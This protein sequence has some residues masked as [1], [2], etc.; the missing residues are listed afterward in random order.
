MSMNWEAVAAISAAA[1]TL[2]VLGTMVAAVIQLRKMNQSN[3][4]QAYMSI[5][6][7]LQV[8]EIREARRFLMMEMA[9]KKEFSCWQESEIVKCE[10]VCAAYDTVGQLL[11]QGAAHPEMVVDHWHS[12]IV[13]CWE[14]AL[15]MITE[16]RKAR[17]EDYWDEFEWLY[18]QAKEREEE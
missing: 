14:A 3:M 16:Y 18:G 17:G 7:Q 6:S 13:K 11:R 2:V 4:I 10:R 12:S 8:P 9:N 5:V 15:P 1:Q